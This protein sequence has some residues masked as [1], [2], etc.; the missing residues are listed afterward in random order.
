MEKQ[1]RVY[2][3]KWKMSHH[4]RSLVQEWNS[5]FI[6]KYEATLYSRHT[7]NSYGSLSYLLGIK[8]L[9]MENI[10]YK[11]RSQYAR[12]LNEVSIIFNNHFEMWSL[13][14]V[15][16]LKQILPAHSFFKYSPLFQI[17]FIKFIKYCYLLQYNLLYKNCYRTTLT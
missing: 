5:F 4:W 1:P 7:G 9:V 11:T 15:Y 13:E 12:M 10:L 17:A 16:F 14:I 3:W 2:Q 6:L 8:L